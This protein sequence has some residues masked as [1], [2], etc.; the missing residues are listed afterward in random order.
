MQKRLSTHFGLSRKA[1]IKQPPKTNLVD[2][3][4]LQTA[5][6]IFQ[7]PHGNTELILGLRPANER[8]CYFVTSFSLAGCKPRISPEIWP[9][10]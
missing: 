5:D 10:D 2:L 7:Y 6:A 1:R 9:S 3:V 4:G 8:R